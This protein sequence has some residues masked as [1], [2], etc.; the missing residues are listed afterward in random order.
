MGSQ[1]TLTRYH[2]TNNEGIGTKALQSASL[3]MWVILC[4]WF[5][6][7]TD[8]IH[9]AN[10]WGNWD[11]WTSWNQ[12]ERNYTKDP[13]N[14]CWQVAAY[15]ERRHRVMSYESECLSVNILRC[16]LY[17]PLEQIIRF[18]HYIKS[19]NDVRK[20]RKKK[21]EKK[22]SELDTCL[23]EKPENKTVSS[24]RVF[25]LC[26]VHRVSSSLVPYGNYL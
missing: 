18:T 26:R 23:H 9:H 14:M 22:N 21:K 17:P 10:A 8:V 3:S 5:C 20:K 2:K 12:C 13:S 11:D 6:K 24:T 1:V 19:K 25:C 16:A 15:G 4:K 7:L